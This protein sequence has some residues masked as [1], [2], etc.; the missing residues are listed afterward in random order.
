MEELATAQV[1]LAKAQERTETTL[2][3]SNERLNNL[4]NVVERFISVRRG[5]NLNRI[6]VAL[7]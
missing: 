1:E 3:G 5:G 2:V 6:T 7:F 4:I